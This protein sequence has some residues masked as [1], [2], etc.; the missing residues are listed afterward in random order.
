MS[1][2]RPAPHLQDKVVLLSQWQD[3]P[4]N[5][6][7]KLSIQSHYTKREAGRRYNKDY[8]TIDTPSGNTSV[9]VV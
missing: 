9:S 8:L 1:E 3:K 2:A 4:H 7:Q 6:K 5:W